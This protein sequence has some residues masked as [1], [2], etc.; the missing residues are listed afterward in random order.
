MGK[1][2]E[3]KT[4]FKTHQGHYQFRVMPFGL[5]N[6]PAT[7]QC[8]MNSILASFLRKFA[9]VFIDDILIYSASWDNHLNHIR[10]VLEKLREHHFF[11]KMSKC[12]FGKTELSYLG[13]IISQNGVATDPSKTEDMINWPR[14][15]NV[16]ELR[17]FLGLT[18]Y[19]RKFVSKYGLLAKPLTKLL[20]KNQFLWS[21]EAEHAFVTLKQA[22]VSTPVLALPQFDKPFVLDTDACDEGIG[23]VLMQEERP[24]ANLSKALGEKN[25]TLSIYEKE[26]LALMLAVD[27]WRQYLQHAEFIIR[28][29]HKAL[30]F[31]ED[32]QLQSHLQR[33][34]MAK[35]MGLQFRIIY[36]KGK[37]N[38]AADALS[39]VG[40]LMVVQT[41]SEVQPMWLQ[42][43]LNSYTTDEVALN[44]LARLAVH[45]PDEHGFSLIGHYQKGCSDLYWQQLCSSHKVDF[46]LA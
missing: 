5:T 3:S 39:R 26:F 44:L 38:V 9:L 7:F 43:V 32:Q 34:A 42:E 4:A 25:K 11:L 24:I 31:L 12:C 8:A 23:A 15:S 16:T 30:S 14:P 6:A 36:R 41:I 35:L 19:Y 2:D 40:H 29:D 28:T 20:Q 45:S 21:E 22:M 17:V 46:C 18:G 37:E 33:K 10:M 13:H 1:E 27:R